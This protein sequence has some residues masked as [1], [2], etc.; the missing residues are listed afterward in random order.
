MSNR[1]GFTFT[2][3]AFFLLVSLVSSGWAMDLTVRD[4]AYMYTPVSQI[5][6]NPN[7]PLHLTPATLNGETGVDKIKSLE[8]QPQDATKDAPAESSENPISFSGAV[9]QRQVNTPTPAFVVLPVMMHGANDKAFSDLPILLSSAVANR[10]S[11]GAQQVGGGYAVMNPIYAYDDLKEKG[12][13]GLYRR[14]IRDYLQ[15]GEPNGEDLTYLVEK[16]STKKRQVK[17]VAFVQAEFDANHS[18][19]PVGIEI[20]MAM[21]LDRLPKEPNF[22]LKGRMQVY[23]VQDDVRL[24]SDSSASSRMRMGEFGN[25]TRS[26]LDDSDSALSFKAETSKLAGKI[27]SDA[28]ATELMTVTSVQASLAP[29]ATGAPA[30]LTPQDHE[31]L[32]RIIQR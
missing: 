3:A 18:L 24:V 13:D 9:P 6:G 7:Q 14:I 28:L 11:Q 16:L 32:K 30:N 23:N 10:L 29:D 12:L 17:W 4:N 27:V 31:A 5:D 15:A 19:K 25:F 2:L 20:P 8:H 1:W 26:V 22:F 21:L